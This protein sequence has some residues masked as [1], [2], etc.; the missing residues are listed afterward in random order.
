MRQDTL[1]AITALANAV[2][3]LDDAKQALNTDF[4]TPDEWY[5]DVKRLM[6]E[7]AELRRKLQEGL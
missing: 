5:A 3:A 7:T 6:R 4:S 1:R 2:Y